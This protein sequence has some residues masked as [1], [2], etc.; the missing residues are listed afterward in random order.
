MALIRAM[1][2]AISGILGQQT[3]IDVIGDNLANLTTTGYKG[4]RA[5]F[6]TMLSQQLTAGTAP[7]GYLGGVDPLQIGLGVRVAETSRDFRNGSLEATGLKTDMALEGDGFFILNDQGGRPVYTRDGSFSINPSNFLHDPSTGFIVQG[8]MADYDNFKVDEAGPLQDLSIPVGDLNIAKSTENVYFDGNLNGGGNLAMNGS[9]HTGETFYIQNTAGLG[10]VT[11]TNP[12]GFMVANANTQL[13]F[14]AL[15]PNSGVGTL[16]GSGS[17]VSLDLQVGDT[18]EL[19]AQKGNTDL[20]TKPFVVGE[21]PPIGGNSIMDLIRYMQGSMGIN[22]ASNDGNKLGALRNNADGTLSASEVALMNQTT[23][24]ET[25]SLADFRDSGVRAGDFLR[26]TTGELAGESF[27]ITEYY[28]D[29]ALQQNVIRID[30]NTPMPSNVNNLVNAQ[31]AIHRPA[32]VEMEF[33]VPSDQYLLHTGLTPG[34]GVTRVDIAGTT[35]L[36]LTAAPGTD[37]SLSGVG[38][39]DYLRWTGGVVSGVEAQ[40]TGVTPNT[41]TVTL[42]TSQLNY[43]TTDPTAADFNGSAFEVLDDMPGGTTPNYTSIFGSGA[44]TVSGNLGSV[45]DFSNLTLTEGSQRVILFNKDQAADGESVVH[46][47]VAYDSLGRA[48]QVSVTYVLEGKNNSGNTWRWYGE[49]EHNL[50]PNVDPDPNVERSPDRI[51]GSGTLMFAT[52][53]QFDSFTTNEVMLNL[54]NTGA[55]TPLQFFMDFTGLTGFSADADARGNIIN[56]S[57]VAVVDQDGFEHG[58]LF[59]FEVGADGLITG[60]FDNGLTRTLGRVQVARFRN[61][62]GLVAEGSSYFRAGVNSG[63]AQVGSPGT[64]ARGQIRSGFLEESNVEMSKQFT[65]LIVA[66][67]AFQA[68]AR[69]ITTADGLLQELVNLI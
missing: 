45:N 16:D 49:S 65:D 69:T 30:P 21:Q 8:L 22:V 24:V 61:N 46:S 13:V 3:R 31:Y 34:G 18:L 59:D 20:P 11:A 5:Q 60:I 23:I 32:G 1:N 25:S 47:F 53:G 12:Q 41:I 52:D 37:F 33:E 58:V 66:Q 40:I 9:V 15:I 36:T 2:S 64:F 19:D 44:I 42:P 6:S 43:I 48:H 51:V 7:Q 26:F 35:T 39:G 27:R 29:T 63:I 57:Q 68:N 55:D 38:V 62:N 17:F 56:Q 10:T 67:R 54:G 50:A 14:D 4:G 28:Y